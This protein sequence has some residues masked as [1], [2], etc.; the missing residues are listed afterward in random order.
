MV[1]RI[2]ALGVQSSDKGIAGAGKPNL[3]DSVVFDPVAAFIL[4]VEIDRGKRAH[5]DTVALVVFDHV[6]GKIMD[7]AVR[8][9]NTRGTVIGNGIVANPDR[10]R[11]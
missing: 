10:I 8:Q 4:V 6:T 9:V 11:A 3:V 7:Q 5:P 1:Y 2:L